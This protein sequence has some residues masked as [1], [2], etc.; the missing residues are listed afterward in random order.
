MDDSR[1]IASATGTTAPLAA[2]HP[3]YAD[4][5]P[6]LAANVFACPTMI[7]PLLA[8]VMATFRR[9]QSSRKPTWAC[10][11]SSGGNQSAQ[12]RQFKNLGLYFD[13]RFTWGFARTQLKTTSSFSLPVESTCRVSTYTQAGTIHV[14][15][16]I[17]SHL[18]IHQ[19][20]L[21]QAF[22]LQKPLSLHQMS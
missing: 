7:S 17:P 20:S 13:I 9:R 2:S 4:Q 3:R 14:D 15:T 5:L 19:Q 22:A 11:A 8:L 18:G 21:L 1:H 10:M 12:G 6:P 16:A